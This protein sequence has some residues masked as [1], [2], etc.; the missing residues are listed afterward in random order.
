MRILD[1][2]LK[3][4]TEVV[5][6]RKSALFLVLMPVLFTLFFGL[7]FAATDSDPRLPVAVLDQDHGALSASIVQMLAGSEAVRLV[8]PQ[9]ADPARL[10][11]MVRDG[12]LSAAL[13]VPAGFA[14]GALAGETAPVT[15]IA[16]PSPASQMAGTAISSAVKRLLGSV[17]SARLA[18]QA[19]EQQQPFADDASRRQFLEQSVALAQAEWQDADLSVSAQV[20]GVP[21][22][23]QKIASGFAQ[24]SPGMMV[25]FAVF[26]L[27]TTASVLVVERKAGTLQRMLTTPLARGKIIAG[28]TLAM[29]A[30]VFGQEVLLVLLGQFAFGVNYGGAPLATL[31]MMVVLAFWA[32]SVGL[33][34]GAAVRREEQVV[35][36]SLI[37]MFVFSA[38]GGAWFPLS[39]AGKAFSTIGHIM[40]TAWAMDGFQ[41]VILGGLGLGGVLV[42]AAIVMLYGAFFYGLALWRF[43]FE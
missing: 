1:I 39:I 23:A 15:L 4:I 34:I 29:F 41:N 3:D 27:I 14:D 13:I 12:K 21:R 24:S 20:A 38:L 17:E 10:D 32:A 28:H 37:A 7:A 31:L 42:P 30:L 5:R 35:M 18:T 2:A 43:R 11:G 19:R 16:L 36:F 6:D 33:L 25:M 9:D 22:S 26:G 40:P 8:D